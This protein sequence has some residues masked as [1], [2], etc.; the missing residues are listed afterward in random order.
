MTDLVKGSVAQGRAPP[1]P[2]AH[3][4][5]YARG[6]ALHRI[7]LYGQSFTRYFSE[8]GSI[9][10]KAQNLNPLN[11]RLPCFDARLES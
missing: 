6:S 3:I 5:E 2:E 1:P 10:K 4:I 8:L 11:S 9:F 7:E